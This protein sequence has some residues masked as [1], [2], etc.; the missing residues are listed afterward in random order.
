M[1]PRK[2]SQP[3]ALQP[4]LGSSERSIKNILT[5]AMGGYQRR[6]L[7][8]RRG[9]RDRRR[10]GGRRCHGGRCRLVTVVVAVVMAVVADAIS[11]GNNI[12]IALHYSPRTRECEEEEWIMTR[13]KKWKRC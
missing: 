8:R 6:L 13:R 10:R 2:M 5:F 11:G 9:R 3:G 1:A 12:A 4:V 7:S